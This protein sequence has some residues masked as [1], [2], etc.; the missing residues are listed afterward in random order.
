ML[1]SLMVKREQVTC[2]IAIADHAP[3]MIRQASKMYLLDRYM[4]FAYK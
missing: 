2:I 1:P 4:V 3:V